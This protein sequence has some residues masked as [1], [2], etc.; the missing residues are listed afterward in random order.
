MLVGSLLS[1]R[2]E[3]ACRRA[4]AW[5]SNARTS[6]RSCSCSCRPRPVLLLPV[7]NILKLVLSSVL[8]APAYPSTRH[9]IPT[10]M[11]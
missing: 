11:L 7:S 3:R 4:C 5:R 8:H 9:Y 10:F 6:T 2:S 1:E